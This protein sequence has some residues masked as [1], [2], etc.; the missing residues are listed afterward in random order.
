MPLIFNL[1]AKT[2]EPIKKIVLSLSDEIIFT[3]ND[4]LVYFNNLN[5]SIDDVQTLTFIFNNKEIKDTI[6]VRMTDKDIVIIY[7]LTNN[8]II[9]DKLINLFNSKGCDININHPNPQ[10]TSIEEPKDSK[11]IISKDSKSVIS[12]DIINNQN[13]LTLKLFCDP[14]FRSLIK[15]Y[16]SRPELFNIL[17]QYTQSGDIIPIN[18]NN[19]L[20]REEITELL[21]EIKKLNLNISDDII[22]NKL[23]KCNGHLN[24][25][26][27]ALL[28]DISKN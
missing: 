19:S 21:N 12:K 3:R 1:V 17:L 6:T 13:K 4:L 20:S 10:I 15:I 24:L 14:D 18:N 2:F 8:F 27:R 22:I 23:I 25:T 16:L 26:L 9:K 5:L 28:C 11:P 7:V